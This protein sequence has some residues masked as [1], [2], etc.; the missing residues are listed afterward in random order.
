MSGATPRK[1]WDRRPPTDREYFEVLGEGLVVHLAPRPDGA[2]TS[3]GWAPPTGGAWVH[4][5]AEGWVHAFTGKA[6]V[7]Q[8]TRTALSLLVAEELRLPLDRVR[9]TMADTDLSP[10]D[11]GTFGSR[12]M[13]DAAPALCRVAAGA[14]ERLVDLAAASGLGPRPDLEANDGT[15]RNRHSGRAIAYGELVRG[16]RE[17]VAL[18]GSGSAATPASEWTRAGHETSDP[19]GED[20]VTGRRTFVSDLRLPGMV[21][22]AVLL[23]PR[24]GGRLKALGPPYPELPEGVRLVHE[25]DWVGALASSPREA[26]MALGRVHAEW[27]E[28]E[29]P[30]EGEI[31]GYLRTHRASGDDWDTAEHHV[32]DPERALRDASV[33][34]DATYRTAYIAHVPLETRAAVATWEGG[35]VTIF[36]G[37]QTPFRA[38]DYVARG[39][40]IPLDDVRIV[41]PFTGSGFGGKHG[42]DVALAAARLA[43]KA[44]LPVH[45]SFSREEEFQ[46]GYLR[47]M[48]IIDV[49]AGA[50]ADGRLSGWVFH[51]INAGAAA[52]AT[53]YRAADQKV[54]NELS[55]SPLPQGPYRALAANANNFA[56]ESVMDELAALLRIDPLTMR[57]RNLEDER[58]LTVL[59]RATERAGWNDRL[60]RPGHGFGVALGLEKGGRVATVAEVSVGGDRTLRVDRLV[61]AFEAGAIVHPDNLRSQVE[62]AT[63]MA[64]GGALFEAVHFDQGRVLNP[65]LSDYRVPRFSDL[66]QLEVVLVD[67]PD[68][69]S[70]GAGETP[71]IAVAPAIANAIFDATGQR[72]R[73]LPLLPDGK[74]P[75]GPHSS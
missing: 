18:P 68:L 25:K 11:M 63:V 24:H 40:G 17:L 72:L 32:G 65:R 48:A 74:A 66:P 35:R 42:G 4:V 38:R 21:Y 41:V 60:P 50:R 44:A 37:T 7:G 71:M 69:P 62:G 26:H 73:S 53:P 39:L 22:G 67:R 12:S 30:S 47:P 64:M 15:I 9:L 29:Q 3:G 1:P 45:L 33:R 31:E 27:E 28:S 10:W 54:D 36:L 2:G 5:S 23:P 56:R 20:V 61:T 59:H 57:E 34:V 19:A 55:D 14:R 43:E 52:L 75:A 6:E 58:L 13:P 51:N 8:G 49:R 16:R 70:A 46:H